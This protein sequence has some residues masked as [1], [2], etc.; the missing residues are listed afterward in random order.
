MLCTY[1]SNEQ[2]TDQKEAKGTNQAGSRSRKE[3][4]RKTQ[5]QWDTALKKDMD[6][7]R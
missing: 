6:H 1:H 7:I 2:N 5:A 3:K 4:A